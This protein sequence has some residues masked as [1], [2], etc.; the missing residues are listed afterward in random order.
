MNS[1]WDVGEKFFTELVP[2]ED[3]VCEDGVSRDSLVPS[4]AV[5]P[6]GGCVD[7]P[8]NLQ[9]SRICCVR[10]QKFATYLC[11]PLRTTPLLPREEFPRVQSGVRG[12]PNTPQRA[13]ARLAGPICISRNW[14]KPEQNWSRSREPKSV[15][16]ALNC[17][18]IIRP[19]A[20][21]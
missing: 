14:V 15:K 1:R 10:L 12:K 17:R 4:C 8:W 7:G 11:L 13:G 18:K 16:M 2:L 21:R 5:E 20:H 3:G 9:K 19:F 6:E